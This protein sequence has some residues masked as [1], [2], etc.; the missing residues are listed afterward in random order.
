MARK[1]KQEKKTDNQANV[2]EEL[3]GLEININPF[4]EIETNY[5]IKEINKFLNKHVDDKKLKEREELRRKGLSKDQ[6][7][8]GGSPSSD[9]TD[10]PQ[11]DDNREED[12]GSN[13]GHPKADNT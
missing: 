10:E 11:D 12:S 5:D 1:K 3:K 4:G 2:H 9:S 8:A 7:Q 6:Q 13:E